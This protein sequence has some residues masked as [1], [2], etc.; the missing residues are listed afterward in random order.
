[1]WITV[2]LTVGSGADRKRS[3]GRRR[4]LPRLSA[5]QLRYGPHA[6]GAGAGR[7]AGVLGDERLAPRV[8]VA[9]R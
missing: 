5:V 2:R 6:V 4:S 3:L 8:S 1:M 9:G 7:V